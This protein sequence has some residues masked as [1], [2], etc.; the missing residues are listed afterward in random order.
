[1]G[2]GARLG[3]RRRREGARFAPDGAETRVANR[4]DNGEKPASWDAWLVS[5]GGVIETLPCCFVSISPVFL[6]PFWSVIP[7]V[8]RLVRSGLCA[9]LSRSQSLQREVSFPRLCAV[10]Q[11]RLSPSQGESHPPLLAGQHNSLKN[12]RDDDAHAGGRQ[13]TTTT[14]AST[15][16]RSPLSALLASPQTTLHRLTMVES[17]QTFGRKVSPRAAPP[18]DTMVPIAATEPIEPL[19]SLALH[20]PSAFPPARSDRSLARAC[21]ALALGGFSRPHVLLLLCPLHPRLP[22]RRVEDR[23]RCCVREARPRPHQAQRCAD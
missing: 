13:A 9:C 16:R 7:S 2:N 20:A 17:V 5:C 14:G 12:V 6:L 21:F 8:S 23:R 18:I 11:T 22:P 1:M 10:S 3:A 4:V 15:H 19:A